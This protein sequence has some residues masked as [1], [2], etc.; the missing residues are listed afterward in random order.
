MLYPEKNPAVKGGPADARAM[1]VTVDAKGSGKPALDSSSTWG[2]AVSAGQAGRGPGG[3][4]AGGVVSRGY[5]EE[6][7]DFAFCVRQWDT[8]GQGVLRQTAAAAALPRRGGDGGRDHRADGQPG[9]ARHEGERNQPERIE[10]KD[11]WFDPKSAEV[12]DGDTK[13][14]IEV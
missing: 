12:P 8:K 11:A 9:D 6:M 7:E 13:P 1:T 5:R 14:K 10:F 3:G 4:S 2:P